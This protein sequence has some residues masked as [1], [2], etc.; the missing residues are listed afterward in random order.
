MQRVRF[1]SIYS[2][3]F[4]LDGPVNLDTVNV[5]VA[6]VNEETF[7]ESIMN[8]YFD[9]MDSFSDIKPSK[10]TFNSVIFTTQIIPD[11][12]D[13]IQLEAEYR[14]SYYF[15]A[16]QKPEPKVA[17]IKLPPP[18][19][20]AHP[21]TFKAVAKKAKKAISSQKPPP[22]QPRTHSLHSIPTMLLKNRLQK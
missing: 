19:P 12:E 2:D 8:E 3:I 21:P 5:N 13:D 11:I 6:E 20:P 4:P 15:D 16:I 7:A 18:P 10:V 9:L 22:F 1:N 17:E 14:L